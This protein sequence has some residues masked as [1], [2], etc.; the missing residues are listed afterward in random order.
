L[1]LEAVTLT[2]LNARRAPS[3]I[4]GFL[5]IG[6]LTGSVLFAALGFSPGTVDKLLHLGFEFHRGGSASVR[7]N[8]V[9]S[10]LQFTADSFGL[11][12]GAGSFAQMIR[13][14]D[15][16][17][18]TSGIVD[19]HNFWIEILAQY[20]LVVFSLVVAWLAHVAW[21]MSRAIISANSREATRYWPPVAAATAMLGYV[22][23]A[24]EGSR[25]IADPVNW[26]FLSTLMVISAR[27]ST[28][29]DGL[30]N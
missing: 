28:S 21:R 9:L 6:T 23:V 15:A 26:V 22:L 19:P 7:L 8:L 29:P 17:L 16:D 14:G 25:F 12:T 5:A 11:G 10:G 18:Q 3:S 30:S 1:A 24:V 2:V 27:L 4:L 13:V 20:G